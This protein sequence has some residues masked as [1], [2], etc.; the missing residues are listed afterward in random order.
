MSNASMCSAQKSLLKYFVITEWVE[1]LQPS[2][3]PAA[4]SSIPVG[5]C[6]LVFGTA[7]RLY[8]PAM[9]TPGQKA[10]TATGS[11]QT[12]TC[13]WHRLQRN[14]NTC[15]KVGERWQG[16]CMY[17]AGKQDRRDAVRSLWL[18]NWSCIY[19]YLFVQGGGSANAC[20]E[21]CGTPQMVWVSIASIK[22]RVVGLHIAEEVII[23]LHGY[24]QYHIHDSTVFYSFW[25][26][27][28]DLSTL[29]GIW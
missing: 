22:W 20:C 25:G 21:N 23:S 11:L 17:A 24:R 18:R 15:T 5:V 12:R 9:G 10:W 8:L 27:F 1:Q 3:R 19:K 28:I 7:A 13:V 4:G 14:T 26:L 6:A 29:L 16:G 2:A